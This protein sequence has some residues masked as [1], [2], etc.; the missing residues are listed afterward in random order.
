MDLTVSALCIDCYICW[1]VTLRVSKINILWR[2]KMRPREGK[3]ATVTQLVSRGFEIWNSPCCSYVRPPRAGKG[4]HTWWV[5][6]VW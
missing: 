2:K 6:S 5:V 4:K 3:L 1:T